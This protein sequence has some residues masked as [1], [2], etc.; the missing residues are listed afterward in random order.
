MLKYCVKWKV[1]SKDCVSRHFFLY[2]VPSFSKKTYR[3]V[4]LTI[5][6]ELQYLLSFV[7]TE[8]YRLQ[9]CVDGVRKE[10]Y[11]WTKTLK[12]NKNLWDKILCN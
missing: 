11:Y 12:T 9:L 3:E 5:K 7:M 6:A 10:H 8:F 1:E 4:H 2:F